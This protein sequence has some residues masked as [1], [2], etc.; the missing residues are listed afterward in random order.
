[1]KCHRDNC[2]V[3]DRL[4]CTAVVPR[5]ARTGCLRPLQMPRSKSWCPTFKNLANTGLSSWHQGINKAQITPQQ[6]RLEPGDGSAS[7]APAEAEI[8]QDIENTKR[9]NP[10]ITV[11][12]DDVLALHHVHSTQIPNEI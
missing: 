3:C 5:L 8:V 12:Q 2:R 10:E 4:S 9:D 6:T 7:N 1:M 11:W